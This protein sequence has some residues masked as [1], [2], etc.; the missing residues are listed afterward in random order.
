[1]SSFLVDI[2]HALTT[3]H[4]CYLDNSKHEVIITVI[5]VKLLLAQLFTTFLFLMHKHY[6]SNLGTSKRGLCKL[7]G[8]IVLLVMCICVT[9]GMMMITLQNTVQGL[10]SFP[11]RLCLC[12]ICLVL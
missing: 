5:F 2:H 12:K 8:G 4:N 6:P 11:C 3:S 7:Y 1:M 9:R 10:V